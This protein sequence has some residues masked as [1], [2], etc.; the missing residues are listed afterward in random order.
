M[1]PYVPSY[2]NAKPV[3]QNAMR[4]IASITNANP[5]L[6]TTYTPHQYKNGLIVRLDIPLGLGMQQANQLLGTVTVVS[7][8]TFNLNIDTTY[9]DPYTSPSSPPPPAFQNAMVVPVGEVTTNLNQP[10]QNV[11]PYPAS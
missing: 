2:D 11:L 7:P 5:V 4:V 1:C 6:V 3:F 9:F 8:T 10:T